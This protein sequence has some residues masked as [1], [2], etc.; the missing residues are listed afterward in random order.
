MKLF[1]NMFAL[2]LTAFTLLALTPNA[3]AVGTVTV[4]QSTRIL[5]G[6]A[7]ARVVKIAWV[8]DASAGTVPDT[9]IPNLHG[10]LAKAITKPGATA[11]TASYG[12]TFLDPDSVTGDA[13]NAA[14]AG[15]SATA[16]AM[17]WP[18]AASGGSPLYFQP[19]NYTFHL[20]S[21][22]V[23]SATGTIWLFFV[24]QI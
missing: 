21:N 7:K 9:V 4:T 3:F 18:A 15:L 1:T 6:G 8:A 23:N 19:G 13:A 14:F 16:T 5:Q 10:F 22:S 12:I 2:I 24:N 20:A 11:P 17:F